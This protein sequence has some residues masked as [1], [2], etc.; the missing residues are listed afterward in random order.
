VSP[1]ADDTTTLRHVDRPAVW[2]PDS[3]YA[4]PVQRARAETILQALPDATRTVLDVGC[5]DGTVTNRLGEHFDVVGLDLSRS[6]LAHVTVPN[7]VGTATDLPFDARSFD[8]V[9]LSEVLEHLDDDTFTRARAE[10]ARV[11]AQSV[12]VTVPNREVLRDSAVRCPRCRTLFSPWQHRRSFSP[13][14]FPALFDGFSIDLIQEIGPDKPRVTRAEAWVRSVA[15]PARRL[16]FPAL[17]PNCGLEGE[18]EPPSPVR[19][20]PPD[21]GLGRYV[22]VA[23]ELSRRAAK[24]TLR[25]RPR[26]VWLLG[27][28]RASPEA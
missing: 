17:C 16:W 23:L 15:T 20:V 11:A 5:G 28:W 19:R 7:V 1:G 12:I 26:P 8:A 6:A 27:R 4:H 14:T 25:P 13:R 21:R 10:A 22:S 9:V 18:G 3:A 2:G 24:R